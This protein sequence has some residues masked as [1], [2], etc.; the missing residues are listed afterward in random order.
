MD[1]DG[2]ER[3][4]A[5][6]ADLPSGQTVRRP[7]TLQGV[8]TERPPTHR[9]RW[10]RRAVLLT[11]VLVAAYGLPALL[12][13]VR[14]AMVGVAGIAP[15]VMLGAAALELASLACFSGLTVSLLGRARRP[16]F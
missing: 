14:T 12:P 16:R 7:P 8:T 13:A 6:R 11:V 5:G 1:G 9:A 3:A 2:S 4:A 15:A 10:L